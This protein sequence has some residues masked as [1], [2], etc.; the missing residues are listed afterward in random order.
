MKTRFQDLV[1]NDPDF[2]QHLE[3]CVYERV[4]NLLNDARLLEIYREFGGEIFRRSSVLYG[5]DSFLKQNNVSGDTCLEIGTCNGMTAV[6]LSRYFK[7][8]YSVDIMP[9]SIKRRILVKFGIDNITFLD[10]KDNSEKAKIIKSIDF[11]FA[12]M[13]GDHANDT[14]L[15]W[16]LVKHCGRVLFH[17]AWKQQPP[18]WK[19]VKS[20][21][22]NQV[23]YGAFNMALWVSK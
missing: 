2:E 19:L 10:A 6:V 8:V 23:K 16:A 1:A 21:P 3:K 18:V 20:L 9:S 4:Q 17:E 15:D 13:D 5:L 7:H 11:D 12:F 22:A 14:D